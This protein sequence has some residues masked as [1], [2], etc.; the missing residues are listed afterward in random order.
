MWIVLSALGVVAAIVI[1]VMFAA[2][3]R[4]RVPKRVRQPTQ[5][6]MTDME[7]P[8]PGSGRSAHRPDGSP[9]PG[10]QEDRRE[11]GRT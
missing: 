10:S 5:T 4:P 6:Q 9:V 11:H 2:K 8:D 7:L 1:A 3:R